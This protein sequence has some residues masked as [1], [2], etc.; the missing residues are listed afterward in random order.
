MGKLALFLVLGFSILYI[1]LGGSSSKLSTQTVENMAD[2]NANTVAH[3]IAVSAT[4]LACNQIFLNSSWNDGFSHVDFENGYFDANVQVLDPW[5][6]IRKLTTTAQY[7]DVTNSIEVIFQPSSFSKYA[8]YSVSESG[9]HWHD[10]DTVWGP[11]HSQD[12]ITVNHSPVFYGKVTT[13][14]DIIYETVFDDP[15]FYGGFE[16][17]INVSMPTTSITDLEAL[18]LDEGAYFSGKDTVFL[19]FQGDSVLYRSSYNSPD[20]SL[21]L[22]S[23][24]PNGILF[25][26]NAVLRLQGTI[27]G[28]Y[29]VGANKTIYIDNDIVYNTDPGIDATS[30]DLFGIVA[31]KDV[32][33]ADLPANYDGINLHASI[34]CMNEGFGAQNPGTR[35]NSGQLKLLGGI[36]QNYRKLVSDPWPAHGF[37]KAYKYDVRLMIASPPGY[38]GTGQ[39]EILSWFE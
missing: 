16:K 33:V 15:K 5:R 35:P 6:N 18:A 28:R 14:K 31:E 3:N 36:Q 30:Q 10:G 37:L 19:T 26:K 23:I 1:I 25:A 12:N 39:L 34:F 29:T 9:I 8:Y 13:K 24:A 17:G 4:N 7:G 2:Y 21:L 38:P 20:S 11:W 32:L 27:K 22:S